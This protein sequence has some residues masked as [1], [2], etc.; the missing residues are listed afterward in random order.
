MARAVNVDQAERLRDGYQYSFLLSSALIHC[1]DR[2]TCTQ[3][4]VQ[5]T[6]RC[7][8][9]KC[10]LQLAGVSHLRDGLVMVP[11][12]LRSG[13]GPVNCQIC[14]RATHPSLQEMGF[15]PG[16]ASS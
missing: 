10:L 9:N 14:K 16:R 1:C 7:V 6:R 8:G 4:T 2:N 15:G 3:P 13:Y 12:M 5:H 11:K